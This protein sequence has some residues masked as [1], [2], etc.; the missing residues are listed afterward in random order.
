MSANCCSVATDSSVQRGWVFVIWMSS[1]LYS[2]VLVHA[3][4][5]PSPHRANG[6]SSADNY[7]PIAPTLTHTY[8][9][10]IYCTRLHT[11]TETFRQTHPLKCYLH[12]TSRSLRPLPTAN[13]WTPTNEYK[14]FFILP[15]QR[16]AAVQLELGPPLP[17]PLWTPYKCS[18]DF[19][20]YV[21]KIH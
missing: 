9:H 3:D 5:A 15:G 13:P 12:S 14:M 21:T 10:H 19:L 1:A 8:T 17:S 18:Y 16:V 7:S 4:S 11:C 2:F 6:S 20:K